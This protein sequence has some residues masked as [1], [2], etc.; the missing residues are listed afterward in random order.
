MDLRALR[1]RINALEEEKERAGTDQA[2]VNQE[3]EGL[4]LRV[5]DLQVDQM[6]LLLCHTL[7]QVERD[8]HGA[9][10]ERSLEC[11]VCLDTIKPPTQVNCF[12]FYL[13]VY[14]LRFGS[15]LK[16]TLSVKPVQT[17]LD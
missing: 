12:H 1:V 14:F 3:L 6:Y 15:V 17:T 16:D 4:R 5:A 13:F 8:E 11:P 7:I 2:V 10:I 9:A